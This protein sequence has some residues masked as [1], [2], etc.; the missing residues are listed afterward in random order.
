MLPYAQLHSPMASVL[1]MYDAEVY[2]LWGPEDV[3]REWPAICVIQLSAQR[4]LYTEPPPR[5]TKL[6][7][8]D[9]LVVTRPPVVVQES[10]CVE[11]F[12]HSVLTI[13]RF[14]LEGTS[15]WTNLVREPNM[16]RSYRS[17]R[18][19]TN[20]HTQWGMRLEVAP[21]ERGTAAGIS[22]PD[23]TDAVRDGRRGSR[24]GSR[25]RGRSRRSTAAAAAA[26]SARGSG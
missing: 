22:Q 9:V 1:L 25:S 21:P 18:H 6:R 20:R 13:V 24:S 19:Y 15:V 12:R 14:M 16:P 3:S 5:G 4:M 26:A 8:T 11:Y 23:P 10:I 17:H 2:N 7:A